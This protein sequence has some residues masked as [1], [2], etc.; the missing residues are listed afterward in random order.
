MA[1]FNSY[2]SHYQRVK[3]LLHSSIHSIPLENPQ[4]PLYYGG[5]MVRS[6]GQTAGQLGVENGAPA[7][8][9]GHFIRDNDD[10]PV[11]GKGYL[12]VYSL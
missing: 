11:H 5:A 7:V 1:I 6:N 9:C 4:F 10:E 2:V 3:F 12:Y 8:S